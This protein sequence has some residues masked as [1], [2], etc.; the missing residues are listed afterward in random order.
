MADEEESSWLNKR[1]AEA[2]WEEVQKKT[3]C[4]WVNLH[5]KKRN[6][7]IS[8]LE[9]DL[10]DGVKLIALLEILGDA[11]IEGRY[12]RNP[13]SKPYKIDNVNFALTYVADVLGVKLISCSAEDVVDGNIK[14]ILGMVWKLIQKFQLPEQVPRQY[15]LSWVRQVTKGYAGFTVDNF[16][17]SFKNGLAFCAIVHAFDPKLLDFDTINKRDAAH[18]LTLAFDL[19]EDALDIPSLLDPADISQG[20]ADERSVMTYISMIN[21]AFLARRGG[22]PASSQT[23]AE[24]D[25]EAPADKAEAEEPAEEKRL[26]ELEEQNQMLMRQLEALQQQHK[27]MAAAKEAAQARAEAAAR[28]QAASEKRAAAAEAAPPPSGASSAR[29]SEAASD[30]ETEDEPTE[31]SEAEEAEKAVK[32]EEEPKE[33]PKEAPTEEPTEA[34]TEEPREAAAEG[35]G[36]AA[37]LQK[38]LDETRESL[39]QQIQVGETLQKSLEDAREELGMVQKRHKRATEKALKKQQKRHEK[40]LLR[41]ERELEAVKAN[42]ATELQQKNDEINRLQQQLRKA[43][44]ALGESA[45][46]G[47]EDAELDQD[48]ALLKGE[49]KEILVIAACFEEEEQQQLKKA[50]RPRTEYM[51]DDDGVEE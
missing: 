39:R 34:P 27:E 2:L 49:Y 21:R 9:K 12:Y 20:L 40:R 26:R 3:F 7:H 4:G 6:M 50:S 41:R 16:H 32:A 14:I 19:L 43:Q 11:K 44:A 5:L 18:N 46:D 38:E 24:R 48:I 23:E 13:K 15:L 35:E 10:G 28:S 33:E 36:G 37:R 51:D 8:D 25:A 31:P 30:D 17:R 22:A 1:S 47:P 45:R 42:A 29:T